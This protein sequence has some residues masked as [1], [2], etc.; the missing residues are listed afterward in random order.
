[1]NNLKAF[2]SGGLAL[3]LMSLV[4]ACSSGE[5]EL[6]DIENGQVFDP[7]AVEETEP[8]PVAT[9]A[10]PPENGD[11]LARDRSRGTGV[12]T[13]RVFSGGTGHTIVNIRDGASSDLVVSFFVGIGE[14]A[15]VSDIPDGS[16]K[17]QYANGFDLDEECLNFVT[18]RGASEDPELL[19]FAPGTRITMTYD[20]MP[21]RQGNFTGQ[22]ISPSDF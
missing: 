6:A 10:N 20:M 2:A 13:I 16:Y 4:S 5:P 15:S 18:I 17:V 14:E 9:C 12:H 22:S 19:D 3:G 7:I 8:E 11:V 21:S 1:M